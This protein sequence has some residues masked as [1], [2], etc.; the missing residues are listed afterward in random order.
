V[1]LLS[2]HNLS[3][4]NWSIFGKEIYIFRDLADL[5]LVH[6]DT[7]ASVSIEDRKIEKSDGSFMQ[8]S[9]DVEKATTRRK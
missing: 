6:A 5:G 4:N 9:P 8:H 1:A 2:E 7:E 3:G